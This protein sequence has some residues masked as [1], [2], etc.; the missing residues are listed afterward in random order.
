MAS[1]CLSDGG[2]EAARLVCE[3]CCAC[4]AIHL[5]S[6]RAKLFCVFQSSRGASINRELDR[7]AAESDGKA[8]DVVGVK[9]TRSC[10]SCFATNCELLALL[11]KLNSSLGFRTT[12]NKSLPSSYRS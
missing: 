6:S 2:D 3:D 10:S 12:F 9:C 1:G 5:R 11:T 4:L 8:D 7:L